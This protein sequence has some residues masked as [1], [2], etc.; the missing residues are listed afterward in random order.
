MS[1]RR[2][3]RGVLRHAAT[4]LAALYDDW[5]DAPYRRIAARALRREQDLF[6]LLVMSEALGI[7]NPASYYALELMPFL[8]EDFHA[9][10]LRMGMEHSP[11][12]G[13]RCC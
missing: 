1:S 11:L 2:P 7:P 13:F 4:R 6:Q 9:W 3:S 5:Y 12:E 8:L 10:H